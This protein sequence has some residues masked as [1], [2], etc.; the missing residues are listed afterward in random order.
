MPPFLADFWL[1]IATVYYYLFLVVNLHAGNRQ[2]VARGG[3]RRCGCTADAHEASQRGSKGPAY[4]G[5]GHSGSATGGDT[6]RER[7]CLPFNI[8]MP[9]FP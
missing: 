4:H 9:C 7:I 6:T 3:I 8:R 5:S 2:S 1:S